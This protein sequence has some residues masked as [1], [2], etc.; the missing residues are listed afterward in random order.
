MRA[1]KNLNIDNSYRSANLNAQRSYRQDNGLAV[2]LN[3]LNA[4]EALKAFKNSMEGDKDRLVGLLDSSK[5]LRQLRTTLRHTLKANGGSDKNNQ[6]ER[7]LRDEIHSLEQVQRRLRD[8]SL[9]YLMF[10]EGYVDNSA[11]KGL[12]DEGVPLSY[13]TNSVVPFQVLLMLHEVPGSEAVYVLP[14]DFTANQIENVRQSAKL[15]KTVIKVPVDVDH[16]FDTQWEYLFRLWSVRY[17][18]DKVEFDFPRLKAEEYQELEENQQHGFNQQEDGYFC[19]TPATEYAFYSAL[20]EV[21]ARWRMQMYLDVESD[22]EI[23]QLHKMAVRQGI[24]S[25]KGTTQA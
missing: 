22:L 23:N 7:K 18:V 5:Q 16:L 3:G 10:H 8:D 17:V 25:Q 19:V 9:H 15:C 24:L 1:I 6:E 13:M 12:I 14:K 4:A 2:V 21:L 11:I 20:H